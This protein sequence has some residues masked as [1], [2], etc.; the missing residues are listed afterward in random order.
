MMLPPTQNVAT[1][2]ESTTEQS[3]NPF[4]VDPS[5]HLWAP[6]IGRNAR[7]SIKL[8]TEFQKIHHPKKLSLRMKLYLKDR[9]KNELYK[10]KPRDFSDIL[11]SW[12]HI[13]NIVI[14]DFARGLAT[15]TNLRYPE[16]LTFTPHE[17]RL[18]DPTDDNIKMAKEG[19]LKIS[20]PWLN[21]KKQVPD[22]HGHPITGSAEHYALN[23]KFHEENSKDKRDVLRKTGLVAQLAGKVNSQVAEQFFSKLKK[24][25][26][27]LNMTLPSTHVFLMRSII[28]HHNSQKNLRR[29]EA[30]RRVFGTE[31]CVKHQPPGRSG[32]ATFVAQRQQWRVYHGDFVAPLRYIWTRERL[33][34]EVFVK[35]GRQHASQEQIFGIF[36]LRGE[37]E[38]MAKTYTLL[39]MSIVAT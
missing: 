14:Y 38:L 30:F 2:V 27:F 4:T 7:K 11:L 16:A 24:N 8:T 22:S 29:L 25:N 35:R 10:K 6:W 37:M 26:Y 18:A 20:L 23:D 33:A 1:N 36:G 3:D 15:H 17:G 19:K 28:H 31:S 32:C 34:D 21:V 9:L 13:P 39:D 12:K 5:Y